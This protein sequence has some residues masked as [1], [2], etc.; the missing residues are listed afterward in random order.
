ME[1]VFFNKEIC[2]YYSL[3]SIPLKEWDGQSS[4][5]KGV[6]V[7]KLSQD[8]FAY[9]G[10]TFNN[11][12]DK[13]PRVVKV[14]SQEMFYGIEKV[15]PVPT[16]LNTD[17]ETMDLDNESKQAAERLAQEANELTSV[18]NEEERAIEKEIE[19]LP[20]WVFDEIKNSEQA[21]AWLKQYNNKHGIRGGI[22]K[23]EETLKLRL[24]NIYY[25]MKKGNE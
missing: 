25:T 17:V 21:R 11:E 8:N 22:P 3:P 9:A 2:E 20:E 23:N 4:F 14:F 7:I 15:Y 13:E 6:C 5:T 1:N 10:C 24:M 12:V 19:K 16:Y 18:E